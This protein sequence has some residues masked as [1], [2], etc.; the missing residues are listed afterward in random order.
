MLIACDSA[1]TPVF[2][3]LKDD[4][5]LIAA[6]SIGAYDPWIRNHANPEQVW[7]MFQESGARY[8]LPIH[9]ATFKLSKE[10][11]DEPIK[12]LI[13]DA[14]PEAGR[15]VIRNVG[16]VFQ[17]SASAL[18]QVSVASQPGQKIVPHLSDHSQVTRE[19]TQ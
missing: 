7:E 15:I 8:L 19:G 4:P 16:G 10:P 18:H 3:Q 14:G 2:S 13:L 9:W 6:F 11:M 17:E 5:P 12:R 1:F